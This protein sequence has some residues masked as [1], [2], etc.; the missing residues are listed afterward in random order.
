MSES[1]TTCRKD[2]MWRYRE[3]RDPTVREMT[4]DMHGNGTDRLA[5]IGSSTPIR[6]AT[7]VI[8]AMA[9]KTTE[10]ATYTVTIKAK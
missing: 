6:D 3:W 9:P 10:T 7:L 8:A 2:G 4:V 1:V 5:G